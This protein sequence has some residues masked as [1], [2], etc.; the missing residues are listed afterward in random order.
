M[1][2]FTHVSHKKRRNQNKSKNKNRNTYIPPHARSR[3]RERES[4][5]QTINVN[6]ETMFPSLN[7]N[8]DTM[9]KKCSNIPLTNYQSLFTEKDNMNVETQED[10]LPYGWV[11]YCKDGTVQHSIPEEER[12]RMEHENEVERQYWIMKEM[13]DKYQ[14]YRNMKYEY[15]FGGYVS[16]ETVYS[17]HSAS[18]D[19][20]AEDYDSYDDDEYLDDY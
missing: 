9:T 7:P 2:D 8:A 12:N 14:H 19:G 4:K 17:E 3:E 15:A 20:D 16:D 1:S 6:D 10:D 13:R 5:K 18:V 11:K